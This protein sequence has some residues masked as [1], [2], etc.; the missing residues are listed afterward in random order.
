MGWQVLKTMRSNII[1][2]L[3]WFFPWLSFAGNEANDS[4]ILNR[5]SV[6]R[7]DGSKLVMI[8]SLEIQINTRKGD[9]ASK[10]SLPY[11]KN[12]K[13]SI[14]EAWIEDM[15]GN[16]IRKLKNS[17]ITTH[18]YLSGVTFYQDDFVKEFQLRH[19][20][21]PYKI[22]L[23]YKYTV[24]DFLKIAHWRACNRINQSVKS[25]TLIV[26]I[27]KDYPI[28]YKCDNIA[29]PEINSMPD[30]T[31]YTW[32]T[33]YTAQNPEN[34]APYSALKIPNVTVLPLHF[35]YGVKGSW[36]T[37][38]TFGNWISRLNANS[39]KLPLLEQQQIDQLLA[40]ITDTHQKIKILYKYLQNTTRYI[41]VDINKGG[42]KTYP[43]E[44]V[45][46]NKYGDCKALSNYMISM[47][48]YIGIPAYYTLINAGDKIDEID[49]SF[50]HQAFNH[51][52][53]TVPLK[54]D[55]L[56]L[57]CT[58]KNCPPGYMGTFTQGRKAFV[59]DHK[60]YFVQ[61]P[62]MKAENVISS[63]NTKVDLLEN[64]HPVEI[65]MLQK[66]LLYDIY[67]NVSNNWTNVE[68]ERLMQSVFPN[69]YQLESF[70]IENSNP[71]L[72]EINLS[73]TLKMQDIY[74]TYGNDIFVNPFARS[75]PDFETPE[76]RIQTV[77]LDY[78][79][80]YSDTSIYIF[81]DDLAIKEISQQ[82]RI[83]SKY[84]IC[85]ITYNFSQNQLTVTKQILIFDG[86]YEIEEYPSFY[87]SF[88]EIKNNEQQKIHLE[89]N[90]K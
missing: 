32:Q 23:C 43:A 31:V 81:P 55:T 50:P 4:E 69:T 34:F 62:R 61:I 42:L 85:H 30:K 52:I 66:G 56:F 37:W 38:E 26:E 51:V 49:D 80:S 6:C 14:E 77:Q 2:C 64:L 22:F 16:I 39:R 45:A 84:G 19:N 63:F 75:L 18:S 10:F 41:N 86:K 35:K 57:E 44:Y 67:S 21:Y 76:N 53:V 33:E 29:E 12:E 11:S 88:S 8:D 47:L 25:S 72:P 78:P 1:F 90:R 36:E 60:S 17:D 68:K 7:I 79:L 5:I 27:P 3:I 71:D 89:L 54:N 83:D 74:K 48:E 15:Q 24:S 46:T 87:Q 28:K 70:V 13:L 20:V 65:A 9:V 58:D 73:V 82:K 59:I 40:G